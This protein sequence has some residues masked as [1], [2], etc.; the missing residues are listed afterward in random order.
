MNTTNLDVAYIVR[1][2]D[3]NEELRYSL[4]SLSNL[5][6]SG[7]VYIYGYKPEWV[8]NVSYTPT[9]QRKYASVNSLNNI[10]T[11]CNDATLSDPFILMH[12]D[13]FIVEPVGEILP[14][15]RGTY[16]EMLA[17]GVKTYHQQRMKKTLSF[18]NSHRL[19][20][21]CYELHMPFI[22]H[23]QPFL[24]I[25]K[26]N[27]LTGINKMSVYGNYHKMGGS[28]VQDVKVKS[29]DKIPEGPYISTAEKTFATIKAGE[30]IRNLFPRKSN[31]EK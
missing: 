3:D 20:T 25:V 2:G 1:N 12:D 11:A 8:Q 18:L 26:L 27:R 15:H 29:S 30:H 23:K 6:F 17:G 10:V 9:D 28:K 21:Y 22:I 4:R 24:E 13:F 31:Y 5:D 19:G 16:Q 7:S 14:K